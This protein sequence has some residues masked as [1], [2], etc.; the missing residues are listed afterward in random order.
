MTK[1]G[2]ADWPATQRE[3]DMPMWYSHQADSNLC[4]YKLYTF[5][6]VCLCLSL[7]CTY[8]KGRLIQGFAMLIAKHFLEVIPWH[9]LRVC[10]ARSN[11]NMSPPPP[12]LLRANLKTEDQLEDTWKGSLTN[13]YPLE[14][15]HQSHCYSV[16]FG[17]TAKWWGGWMKWWGDVSG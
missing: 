15:F 13:R 11:T 12:Q 6:Y 7:L 9:I 8:S 5:L 4:C 1:D 10:W 2:Q 14:I 3:N 17:S 16:P